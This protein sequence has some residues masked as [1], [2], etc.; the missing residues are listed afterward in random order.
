MH[1]IINICTTYKRPTVSLFVMQ[2]KHGNGVVGCQII[3][4]SREMCVYIRNTADGFPLKITAVMLFCVVRI[5]I[6]AL[7]RIKSK[8]IV[9]CS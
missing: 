4:S 2:V 7:R 8:R 6:Y 5:I 1:L 3:E 9:Y